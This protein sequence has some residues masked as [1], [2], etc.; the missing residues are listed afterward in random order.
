VFPGKP[1]TSRELENFSLI[2][3]LVQHA[4]DGVCRESWWSTTRKSISLPF[5]SHAKTAVLRHPAFGDIQLLMTLMREITVECRPRRSA[6]WHNAARR[7]FG[8]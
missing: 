5:V 6:P 8:T 1:T 7:R 2:D 3:S 4:Q